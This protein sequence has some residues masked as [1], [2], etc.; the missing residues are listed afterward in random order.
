MLRGR[1]DWRGEVKEQEEGHTT[2]AVVSKLFPPIFPAVSRMT[3]LL[4][5]RSRNSSCRFSRRFGISGCSTALHCTAL[6]STRIQF[7]A[8]IG[9]GDRAAG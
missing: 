3:F 1:A 7:R 2:W 9:T 4:E 8:G 6:H 5:F